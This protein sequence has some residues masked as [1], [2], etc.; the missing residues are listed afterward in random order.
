MRGKRQIFNRNG[1]QIDIL[2]KSIKIYMRLLT[3][4]R[5]LL[6]TTW[7]LSTTS[8]NGSLIAIFRIEVMSNPYTF[9]HLNKN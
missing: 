9:S 7:L 2:K 6:V 3:L 8:T 5:Q 4:T 1:V